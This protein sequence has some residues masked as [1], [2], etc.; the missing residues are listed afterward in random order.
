MPT[1]LWIIIKALILANLLM[2][3]AAVLLLMERKLLAYFQ[4]RVGPNRVGPWGLL[5]PVADLIKMIMKE[6]IIPRDADHI[7]FRVAPVVAFFTALASFAIIP[8]GPADGFAMSNP[9]AGVLVFLAIA[10]MTAYGVAL[11]GWASQSKYSLLGSMRATAQMISYELSMGMALIG[12]ILMAGS[13]RLSD[14]VASQNGLW[15]ILPQIIGFWI[16]FVSALAEC[17]RTPFDLPEAEAELVGG[18]NTEYAGMRFGMFFLGEL[19]HLITQSSLI[20][21]LY[22]GG[23]NVPFFLPQTPLMGTLVFLLKV[24]FMLFVFIW[25]RATVPR[26]RYDQLMSYGWKRMLPLAA[27]NLVGTAV[28]VALFQA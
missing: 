1:L 2:G 21:L 9:N 19:I 15:N 12:V 23:W 27:L 7:V 4:L 28:Y 13:V 25:V 20:T 3:G 14:I 18:Y 22:L 26:M 10:S 8:W 6:D 5:Q 17:S 11:G 16:Y 24:C